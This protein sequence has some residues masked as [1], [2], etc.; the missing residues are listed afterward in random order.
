MHEIIK[1]SCGEIISQC[2]CPAQ[3]KTVVIFPSGCESCKKKIQGM[4]S[5]SE[6][7][8]PVPGSRVVYCLTCKQSRLISPEG[9]CPGCL[10]YGAVVF[11]PRVNILELMIKK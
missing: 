7:Q 5:H 8:A 11:D 3:N 2:R 1:C 10:K 4:L 6:D 9:L